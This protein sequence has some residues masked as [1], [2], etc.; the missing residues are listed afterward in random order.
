MKFPDLPKLS[1]ETIDK[2][3]QA[4][5]E[6]GSALTEQAIQISI[7]QAISVIQISAQQ[8]K[9]RNLPVSNVSIGTQ[10]TIG[11]I[12]LSINVN[13]PTDQDLGDAETVSI[14]LLLPSEQPQSAQP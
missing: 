7:D 10:L 11:I 3:V 14:D 6:H 5:K 4:S 12:Q 2:A 9:K 8:I 1:K 13:V